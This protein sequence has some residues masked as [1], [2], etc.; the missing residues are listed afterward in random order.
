MPPV[1]Q[2]FVAHLFLF[3]NGPLADDAYVALRR[4]WAACRRHLDTTSPIAGLPHHEQL[5]TRRQ[6]LPTG[7]V[8]AGQERSGTRDRQCVLRRVGKVLNLSV[9]MEQPRS[10]RS[11]RRNHDV[12]PKLGWREFADLWSRVSGGATETLLG[13]TVLFLALT[14]RKRWP[15]AS[16]QLADSFGPLLRYHEG[17]RSD[18]TLRGTTSPQGFTVWDTVDDQEAHTRELVI[19]APRRAAHEL[20]SW[21]WSDDGSPHL[22]SFAEYL[23]HGALLRYHTEVVENWRAAP[24]PPDVTELVRDLLGA[25]EALS[26]D[27][28]SALQ[29]HLG[30]LRRNELDLDA[31]IERLRWIVDAGNDSLDQMTRAWGG[32]NHTSILTADLEVATWLVT[33]AERER[34]TQ[35]SRQ[36]RTRNARQLVADE[37]SQPTS[38]VTDRPR[39][40]PAPTDISRNVFVVHGRDQE[41]RQA[42]VT[43]LHALGLN[44]MDWERL[45]AATGTTTPTIMEVVRTAPGIAQATVVL[46]TPD[47]VV[48]LH[49]DFARDQDPKRETDVGGQ[50]RPNVILELGMALMVAPERTI[51]VEFGSLRPMSDLAGLHAIR[52]DGSARSIMKLISR[53]QLAECPVDTSDTH[54]F[55][56]GRFTELGTFTRGPDTAVDGE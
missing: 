28:A 32:G 17:R 5:P 30:R 47:D 51:I 44:P 35:I 31:L 21:V 26:S 13:E 20:S 7:D 56:N 14:K 4:T 48:Q 18:W 53:L 11:E 15:G 1:D 29:S 40:G 6:D 12:E 50:P 33:Q 45:V 37:L 22:P 52:F 46:M 55:D 49:Q 39:G 41:A 27:H 10:Q 54:L 2:E 42:I 19:A 34:D 36:A 8:L 16:P 25:D 3:E 24:R 23:L 9:M 43:I 38:T